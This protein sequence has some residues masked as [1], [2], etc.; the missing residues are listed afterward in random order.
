ME[1]PGKFQLSLKNNFYYMGPPI[2]Q[3]KKNKEKSR[4]SRRGGIPSVQKKGVGNYYL[5]EKKK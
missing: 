3:R 2:L 1:K 4:N 5:R